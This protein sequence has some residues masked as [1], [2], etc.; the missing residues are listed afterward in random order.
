[1]S[2]L[3]GKI[4]SK[5]GRRFVLPL[6]FLFS[7]FRVLRTSNRPVGNIGSDFV[8]MRLASI[9]NSLFSPCGLVWPSRWGRRAKCIHWIVG[10]WRGFRGS[11]GAHRY[12]LKKNKKVLTP[13][14]LLYRCCPQS[15]STTVSVPSSEL[16]RT[17]PLSSQRVCPSPPNQRGGGTRKGVRGWGS[18]NSDD[19][20]KILSL[21]LLCGA[22]PE[23]IILV[24]F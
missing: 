8:L 5:F 10:W 20:R 16:G 9:I 14:L 11:E 4:R 17:H 22:A 13:L 19:W 21:C 15:T 2:A 6:I 1:M 7:P 12:F 23:S 3:S 24:D 18:P